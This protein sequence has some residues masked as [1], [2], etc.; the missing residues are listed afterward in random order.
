MPAASVVRQSQERPPATV[1]TTSTSLTPVA[2]RSSN[3]RHRE[4]SGWWLGIPGVAGLSGDGGPADRAEVDGPVAST[5]KCA[6]GRYGDPTNGGEHVEK[7]PP[8]QFHYRQ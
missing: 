1:T 4:G 5:A 7:A 3:G 8:V 6:E 2:T